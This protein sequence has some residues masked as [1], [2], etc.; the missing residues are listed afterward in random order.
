MGENIREF[1]LKMKQDKERQVRK[2]EHEA[3]ALERI[4]KH[5][6]IVLNEQ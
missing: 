6:E 5:E 4:R 1:Y 2:E 3:K